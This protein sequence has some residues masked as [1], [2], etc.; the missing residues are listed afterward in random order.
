MIKA[1]GANPIDSKP[2]DTYLALERG[3]ADGVIC[4]IAPMRAFKITD[5]AKHHTILNLGVDAFWAGMNPENGIAFPMTSR[6]SR[7][8]HR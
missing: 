4:P 8:D 6:I 7:R 3:M 5:A 1:L 2:V